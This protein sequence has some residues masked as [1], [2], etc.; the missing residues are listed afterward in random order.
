M[1]I[2]ELTDPNEVVLGQVNELLRQLDPELEPLTDNRWQQIV[3]SPNSL[4]A[5]ALAG[6]DSVLVGLGCLGWYRV[7][8]GRKGWLEDIVVDAQCRGQG[9]GRQIVKF[10]LEQAR[11]LGLEAVYLTSNPTR[12]AANHLYQALGFARRDTNCY[13][14]GL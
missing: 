8:S 10:L 3:T 12:A 7:A 5:V 9:L 2:R 11:T 4:T 6:D 1:T 13:R 14:F